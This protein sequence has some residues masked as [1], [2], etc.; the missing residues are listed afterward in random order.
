MVIADYSLN[1]KLTKQVAESLQIPSNSN[2]FSIEL[3]KLKVERTEAE[4][5]K[6]KV[7]SLYLEQFIVLLEKEI[8]AKCKPIQTSSLNH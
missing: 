3:E 2:A 8:V 5:F 6:G 7:H 1:I 4:Q